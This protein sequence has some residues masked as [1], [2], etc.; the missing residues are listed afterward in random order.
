M[1]ITNTRAKICKKLKTQRKKP[2]TQSGFHPV[3][4][5]CK[6]DPLFAVALQGLANRR[7]TARHT[8][9]RVPGKIPICPLLR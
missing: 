2:N 8:K 1:I 4:V 6:P 3:D 7:H 9:D 5:G